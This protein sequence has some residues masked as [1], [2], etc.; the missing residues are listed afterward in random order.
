MK[1]MKLVFLVITAGLMSFAPKA[2]SGSP[3]LWKNEVLNV[4]EIPQGVPKNIEFEFTN[5]GKT[6]VLITNVKASCGCTTTDY[7]K[8]KVEPGKTA[9]VTAK[10]NAANKGP[11]TKT[12][13]V[14]TDAEENPKTLSFRGTVI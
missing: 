9:T 12:I 10:Y 11:F 1:A 3:L 14:T 13:T 2:S 4:G 5:N 6:A 7:T 8:T